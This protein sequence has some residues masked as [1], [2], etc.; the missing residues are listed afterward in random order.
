MFRGV[1]IP[2]LSAFALLVLLSLFQVI[3]L[4]IDDSIVYYVLPIYRILVLAKY[5][6]SSNTARWGSP[7]FEMSFL[8][9]V[10]TRL[11]WTQITPLVSIYFLIDSWCP[12][13]TPLRYPCQEEHHAAVRS[14]M[15]SDYRRPYVFTRKL[16][17]CVSCLVSRWSSSVAICFGSSRLVSKERH[18]CQVLAVLALLGQNHKF[19]GRGGGSLASGPRSLL[20]CED[21]FDVF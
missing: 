2:L 6:K 21:F 8:S 19:W 15:S 16:P 9:L 1:R 3:C 7:C 11:C 18:S 5:M 13:A 17:C 20:I 4:G 10:S 12:G 14:L